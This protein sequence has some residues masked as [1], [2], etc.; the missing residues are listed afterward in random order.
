MAS[1]MDSLLDAGEQAA[2]A[3]LWL[4]CVVLLA[5]AVPR[6]TPVLLP[7]S[8]DRADRTLRGLLLAVLLITCVNAVL[9]FAGLLQTVWVAAAMVAI[10]LVS[11][12]FPEPVDADRIHFFGLH[13]TTGPSSWPWLAAAVW[14]G[15]EA[16]A[17]LP[18]APVNWDALTY[19]LYFPARW[20]QEGRIFHIPS[21][22]ADNT[23]AFAPQNGPLLFA[24]ILSLSAS[25]ALCNV[26]QMVAVLA[27]M[28]SVFRIVRLVSPSVGASAAAWAGFLAATLPPVRRWALSAQVD[29]LMVAAWMASVTW[30]LSLWLEDAPAR[31]R[32]GTLWAAVLAGGFCA[33][34][35]TL[36]LV[37]AAP[38]VAAA[39]IAWGVRRSRQSGEGDTDR[40]AAFERMTLQGIRSLFSVAIFAGLL[41]LLAGGWWYLRNLWLY[42]NPLFPLDVSILGL[43]FNG[44]YASAAMKTS[45][46]HVSFPLWIR[47]ITES[48]GPLA[49]G[50]VALGWLRQAFVPGIAARCLTL[51]VPAWFAYEFLV[52]PYNSEVRFLLP[53]L[54]V[55]CCGL[56][57]LLSKLPESRQAMA[58]LLLAVLLVLSAHRITGPYEELWTMAAVARSSLAAYF[59]VAA[60]TAV[61]LAGT[62]RDF[63]RRNGRRRRVLHAVS[64]GSALVVLLA[65]GSALARNT[66]GVLLQMHDYQP[67]VTFE[68]E[69]LPPLNIAYSGLNVPYM[70]MGPGFRHRV[71][72]VNTRGEV[73]DGFYEHWRRDPK[74]YSTHRP[75]IYRGDDEE[76]VWL[77]RLDRLGIDAVVV[78]RLV[79]PTHSEWGVEWP[80]PPGAFPQEREWMRGRPER[81]R[82]LSAGNRWEIYLVEDAR[83]PAPG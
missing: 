45:Y 39:L 44:A 75:G 81:F 4:G 77:R 31:A 73:E 7:G 25:D 18:T 42:G 23:V 65:L 6:L 19:H 15:F 69:A 11:R 52:V 56:A 30:T 79:R 54:V 78:Q 35:K 12:A 2:S 67:I 63:A 13:L 71:M 50:L 40:S 83:A 74:V 17:T 58:S 76:S 14:F 46:F 60:I 82:F 66:R 21:V 59:A 10:W 61:V 49:C 34:T 29:V 47:F 27:L 70:L 64:T 37:L 9:G 55:A 3:G 28:L 68:Y 51:F 62:I 53:A 20:V 80:E 33:G 5:L 57:P 1:I 16:L 72:Y 36:G 8:R 48:F 24:W 26:V 22:F 38:V 32:R 41:F 43:H